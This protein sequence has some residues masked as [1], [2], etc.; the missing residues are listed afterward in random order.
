MKSMRLYGTVTCSTRQLCDAAA[1]ASDAGLAKLIPQDVLDNLDPLGTNVL[2]AKAHLSHANGLSVDTF[3]RCSGHFSTQYGPG[4]VLVSHLDVCIG[5]YAAMEVP[6]SVRSSED[7]LPGVTF[8]VP[9]RLLPE[10]P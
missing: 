8:D 4:P 9:A 2:Q 1:H 6:E 10:Q 7:V 5:D 3:I